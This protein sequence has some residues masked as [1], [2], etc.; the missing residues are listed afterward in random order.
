MTTITRAEA[1]KQMAQAVHDFLEKQGAVFDQQA[2][3]E[4]ALTNGTAYRYMLPRGPYGKHQI[5]GLF[6]DGRMFAMGMWTVVFDSVGGFGGTREMYADIP[7]NVLHALLDEKEQLALTVIACLNS[8]HQ[9][10]FGEQILL[11]NVNDLFTNLLAGRSYSWFVEHGER[12]VQV[13]IDLNDKLFPVS[14]RYRILTPEVDDVGLDEQLSRQPS[15]ELK[16]LLGTD[17]AKLQKPQA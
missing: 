14:V 6:Y 4:R 16:D 8:W 13:R 17:I 11:H 5:K 7:Y 10:Q 1:A 9:E 15:I 12:T 2:N 3:L